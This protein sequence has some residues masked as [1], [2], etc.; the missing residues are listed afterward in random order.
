MPRTSELSVAEILLE[1]LSSGDSLVAFIDT[2]S[3]L[4]TEVCA[5]QGYS[6]TILELIERWLAAHFYC[7]AKPQVVS[8]KVGQGENTF[9]QK[10]DLNLNQTRYGQ[11]ALILDYKGSLSEISEGKI[12][13]G[14]F[15]LGIQ[16]W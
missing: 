2:A 1:D 10:V 6:D 8:E 13:A 3:A 5:P 11:Q 7:I 4:V 14:L 12:R 16:R 15:W 9:Q